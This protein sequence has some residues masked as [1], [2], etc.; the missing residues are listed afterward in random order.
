MSTPTLEEQVEEVFGKKCDTYEDGCATCLVYKSLH[1][2]YRN[3]LMKE[4]EH[5]SN[6]IRDARK[7]EKMKLMDD[8]CSACEE[9]G[10]PFKTAQAIYKSL[11]T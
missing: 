2:A 3:G 1:T 7:D 6:Y 9:H 11:S 4:A 8:L 5:T 10:I